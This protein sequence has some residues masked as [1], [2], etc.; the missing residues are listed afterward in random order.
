MCPASPCRSVSSRVPSCLRARTHRAASR[1]VSWGYRVDRWSSSSPV[2]SRASRGARRWSR[3]G[4]VW[5]GHDVAGCVD[6]RDRQGAATSVTSHRVPV[7]RKP[8]V[9][10]DAVDV[11]PL[12]EWLVSGCP[13]PPSRSNSVRHYSAGISPERAESN[14][15]PG[16][17][18]SAGRKIYGH[19]L[20]CSSGRWRDRWL[21]SFSPEWIP[22]RPAPSGRVLS[23]NCFQKQFVPFALQ[24]CFVES[25][26]DGN[27]RA[28]SS[29]VQGTPRWSTPVKGPA[30]ADS[31]S[32]ECRYLVPEKV[33]RM[34]KFR[35]RS[36]SGF[37]NRLLS[38]Q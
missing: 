32:G 3:R 9:A 11:V 34:P 6:S 29:L 28:C 25:F 13:K 4:R 19:G 2:A 5:C 26:V 22:V 38:S 8:D 14:R 35:K 15:P 18:K 30:N 10:A 33:R 36:D 37:D 23:F 17:W 1:V 31:R 16:D 24:K 12:V 7:C 20:A 21:P 27:P